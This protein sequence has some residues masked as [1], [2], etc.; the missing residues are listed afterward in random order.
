MSMGEHCKNVRMTQDPQMSPA[1][2]LNK[3]SPLPLGLHPSTI[4]EGAHSTKELSQEAEG[5]SFKHRMLSSYEE[6]EKERVLCLPT[7][8]KSLKLCPTSSLLSGSSQLL[9]GQSAPQLTTPTVSTPVTCSSSLR[10]SF[11]LTWKEQEPWMHMKLSSS[12]K[13]TVCT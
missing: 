9:L 2:P 3:N 13:S 8:R 4:L 5:K 6:K 1:K 11:I 12:P 7:L 10:P